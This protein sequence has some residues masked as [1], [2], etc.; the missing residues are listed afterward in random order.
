MKKQ[1]RTSQDCNFSCTDM[2][3]SYSDTVVPYWEQVCINIIHPCQHKALLSACQ[4]V[5]I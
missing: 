4:C 1:S 5:H 3:L 2:Q